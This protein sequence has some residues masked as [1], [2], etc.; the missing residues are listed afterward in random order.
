MGLRRSVQNSISIANASKLRLENQKPRINPQAAFQ[1]KPK[2]T[3][4]KGANRFQLA[5]FLDQMINQRLR[6]LRNTLHG[7]LDTTLRINV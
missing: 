4:K 3:N 5:P 7:Q 1:P 2:A 6:F